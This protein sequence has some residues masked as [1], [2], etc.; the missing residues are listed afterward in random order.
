MFNSAPHSPLSYQIRPFPFILEEKRWKW[1]KKGISLA[2]PL[3]G[4]LTFF[5]FLERIHVKEI[6]DHNTQY[7][8]KRVHTGDLADWLER[9]SYC[10]C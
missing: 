6:I 3:Q 5:L 8:I 9:L 4:V 2:I 7:H 1:I 10:Q